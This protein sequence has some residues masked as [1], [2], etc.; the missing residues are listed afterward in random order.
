MPSPGGAPLS[1]APAL[2]AT[3]NVGA[4]GQNVS[5][6]KAEREPAE[7]LPIARVC[8]DVPLAHLDRP[9]DYL[10]AAAD[11]E[12][13]QPGVRVKVRFAGQL[14]GGY[15]LERVETSPHGGK[16]AYLDRVVSAERVLDPEVARLARA[17][18]DR[19][20]GNLSDVLRLA[21]P[22]RHATTEKR[23][24]APAPPVTV[25]VAAAAAAWARYG[26]G[27]E[28]VAGLAGGDR[29]RAVWSALPGDG[30]PALLAHAAAATLAS[31][32]GSLLCLPD[33]KDVARVNAALTDVLGPGQHVVLTADAG[34]ARRYRA[35]LAVSRGA[36]RVVVG[37]RAAAFAPVHD[38]GLVAVWDDGD[39]LY[40]EPR[41]PYPHTREVLLLRAHDEGT[42]AL[43]GGFARTVEGEY[44][45]RTGWAGEVAPDR[46][47]LR[48]ATP[49]VSI[50]GATDR[51]LERDPHARAARLPHT[52]FTAIRDGLT[53][54]PVLLQTPR[55]GYV[56]ALACDSCRTSARCPACAGP[57][58]LTGAHRPPSCRWC[59][60]EQ[61][62]WVCPECAGRGLRAPVLGERRTAEEVGRA[63]PQ[64]PVRVSAG[65]RVLS[66]VEAVPSLVVATPGAEPVV[67]GGYACVVLLDTWLTLARTDLRTAEEALR[68]WLAAAALARPA[69]A[70]GTVVAVG[71]PSSSALQALVRWDPAGFARRELEE[72]QS[73]HL[74]PASRLATLT[75]AEPDLTEALAALDLPP[76][77]EV[78]GPVPVRPFPV[79]PVPVGAVPVDAVPVGAVPAG[80]VTVGTRPGPARPGVR[81]SGELTSGELAS[82]GLASR[83]L[84]PGD[85]AS[86]DGAATGHADE[87]PLLRAVV[88]TP[89]AAGPAL[90]R[91]LAEMQGV[92]AARKLP[93]V[94]VQVDPVALG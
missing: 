13:A 91:T 28:L 32:R 61:R 40:A 87:S 2:F 63:F 30:W 14:V 86:R 46:A 35:F 74:P 72:R 93:P 70:G 21:V 83:G 20:A 71:E 92:R 9:F 29:P 8:V 55:L 82:G 22:P 31:G 88:R 94:R 58:Q 18:A 64:T 51:E 89:R 43:V 77:S 26:G 52:A 68:R 75:G 4:A 67:A 7:R 62:D 11:D 66:S 60:V 44:L 38:L 17:V 16:L 15:L 78:L 37:T 85:L 39:D 42:A 57:L 6:G 81:T 45:L 54:G 69:E 90:S 49:T 1:A 36:V 41:A 25:D 33:H 34:P 53:R 48:S 10:V 73:A 5:V 47:V 19:Y 79:T 59:G 27:P 80:P 65:D 23:A 76:G 84:A 12:A 50:T 56:T 3:G 24:S